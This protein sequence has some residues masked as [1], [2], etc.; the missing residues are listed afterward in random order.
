MWNQLLT[1]KWALNSAVIMSLPLVAIADSW[2]TWEE[3]IQLIEQSAEAEGKQLTEDEIKEWVD[4][5]TEP[6]PDLPS[7][8]R[9]WARSV[10]SYN[11]GNPSPWS[12]FADPQQILNG[13][14]ANG[15]DLTKSVSLG[16]TKI[17]NGYYQYGE[18]TV[19]FGNQFP[20]LPTGSLYLYEVGTD[21]ESVYLQVRQA[22][23]GIYHPADPGLLVTTK[24]PFA[25][26]KLS[27]FGVSNGARL[28][29]VRIRD[30]ADG[31]IGAAAAGADIDAI[32]IDVECSTLSTLPPALPVKIRSIETYL[33]EDGVAVLWQT[34][35]MDRVAQLHLMR[36]P[37]LSNG[38]L[39]KD[40]AIL[41]N[42]KN[43]YY[44]QVY[45]ALESLPPPGRYAYVIKEITDSGESI[46]YDNEI[47]GERA[48]IEIQ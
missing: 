33:I 38:Q 48:I 17:E 35:S 42:Q 25:V 32:G 22:D 2:Q 6:P 45:G 10:E 13:A 30:A 46:W 11:P 23:T 24:F 3:L 40:Q 43:P 29:A 26:I 21:T 20:A 37:V 7:M 14:N 44:T 5:L 28:D 15:I 19:S 34:G 39:D 47:R 41:I 9:C 27:Q 12:W 16:N 4:K 36:V 31:T 8:N 18:I 1:M